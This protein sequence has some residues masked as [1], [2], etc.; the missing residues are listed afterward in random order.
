MVIRGIMSKMVVLLL[1]LV[2][3]SAVIATMAIV[4]LVA[5]N[6]NETMT[7]V[8]MVMVPR[9]LIEKYAKSASGY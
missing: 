7:A 9:S 2:V 6:A 8:A 4:M 3:M 1:A 5:A